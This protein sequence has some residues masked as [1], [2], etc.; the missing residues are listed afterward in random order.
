MKP[1]QILFIGILVAFMTG[2]VTAQ[3]LVVNGD[4]EAGNSGFT[5]AYTFANPNTTEGE[6]CVVKDPHSWNGACASFGDHTSGAGNMMV[7]NGNTTSSPVVWSQQVAVLPNQTYFFSTWAANISGLA[8]STFV[9]R[10]NGATLQ[11]TV[12]LP[13]QAGLWQN[14]TTT[15]N[16]GPSTN[17]LLEIIFTSTERSGNDTALDDIVFRAVSSTGAPVA[18]NQAVWLEWG[19]DLGTDYQIQNSLDLVAWTNIGQ[20]VNGTGGVMT[21]C[22]KITQPRKFYRVIGLPH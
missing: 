12:I 7:A 16:S 20:P 15:W 8:P 2:H 14:Y 4:F 22:E 3:N 5:S 18:I 10:I 21:Y 11:P 17:A 1:H 13:A 6:Y 9:F 19:S